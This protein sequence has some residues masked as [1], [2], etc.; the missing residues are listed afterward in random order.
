MCVNWSTGSPDAEV[1]RKHSRNTLTKLHAFSA[2]VLVIFTPAR[3]TL[4]PWKPSLWMKS[5]FCKLVKL[6]SMGFTLSWRCDVAVTVAGY[7][8]GSETL[9]TSYNKARMCWPYKVIRPAFSF[10]H[11]R[12]GT[13]YSRDFPSRVFSEFNP[14]MNNSPR[15]YSACIC[16]TSLFKNLYIV[17]YKCRFYPYR[18]NLVKTF[19]FTI[20]LQW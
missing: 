11:A 1:L 5:D 7:K 8:S 15:D 17:A 13:S 14:V 10:G 9:V 16:L 4:K 6:L 2:R 20:F 12:C 18:L 3:F 19:F